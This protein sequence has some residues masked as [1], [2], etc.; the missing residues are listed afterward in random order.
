M[1]PLRILSVP[2]AA[3][4]I[5]AGATAANADEVRSRVV[6]YADLDLTKP[7]GAARLADRIRAAANTVCG[8]ADA[9]TLTDI[10][11]SR[12]CVDAAMADAMKKAGAAGAGARTETARL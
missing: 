9:R 4:F 2:A 10:A 1:I 5:V 12:R 7:A 11:V 8:A 3:L 6:S